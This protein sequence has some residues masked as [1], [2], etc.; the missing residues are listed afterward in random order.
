MKLVTFEDIKG[1]GISPS[2]CLEWVE[3]AIA[4]KPRA[5]LPPKNSLKP[6]DGSFMNV[7]PCLIP[8]GPSDEYRWGG[9]KIVT[10]FPN[11]EPSLDSKL[12]LLDARS[13]E[14]LALMDADWITTMRTGAVAAHSILL[15]GKTGFSKLAFMGLGNTARSTLLIL[16]EACPNRQFDIKLLRYKDQA[17]DFAQRFSSYDNLHFSIVDTVEELV[18]GSEVVV[19][20]VTYFDGDVCPDECF[21]EGVLLVPVHTRGFTNCDLFFDKVFADDY[22][23]VHHFKNF[24]KFRSFAEVSSVVNGV[25]PG[26]ESDSERILAYNIGLSIHDIAFAAKIWQALDT[27]GLPEIDL[28]QPT[29]KFWV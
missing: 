20:C 2:Q 8:D 17:E 28:L 29:E 5:V 22:G 25:V 19:S 15:L 9:V 3:K 13:G 12:I 21:D 27:K 7:M 14:M 4:N 10:R 6:M 18:R 26:R 16:A 11:R 1:L 24:D 23:H